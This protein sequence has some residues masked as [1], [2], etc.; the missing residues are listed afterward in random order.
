MTE[1]ALSHERHPN[2][3]FCHPVHCVGT[4]RK[5]GPGNRRRAERGET[6]AMTDSIAHAPFNVL[7]LCTG[8]SARSIIA[9]AIRSREGRG[10]FRAFSAGSQP[11]GVVHPRTLVLLRKMNFDVS[12]FRS[13]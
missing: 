11:N 5:T 2:D 7:F 8:N 9:E 6:P 4:G 13:K 1:G 10:K 3:H 12:G